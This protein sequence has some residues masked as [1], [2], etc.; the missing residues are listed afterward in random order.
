[1]T[2][3]PNASC[4]APE[5]L[6]AFAE[7]RV[8]AAER[9]RVVA[10]LDTCD[11][12][13]REVALGMQA[14]EE[15]NV[16]RPRRWRPWLAAIAAAVVIA[17]VVPV[18]RSFRH[19]PVDRLVALSP[20]DARPIEPRLTGGFA[21]SPY[22]GSQRESGN[23]SSDPARMKLTGEAGELVQRAETDKG[24]EAQHDAGVA[25]VLTDDLAGAI[26]RLE[27]AAKESPSA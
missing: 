17:I 3:E 22:R 19:S 10:H 2:D 12:C 13:T 4:P 26:D 6:A 21:W 7:G 23:I 8:S 18:V 1:M 9:A 16:V 24:A 5:T 11:D 15:E 14:V 25:V 27:K 20:R